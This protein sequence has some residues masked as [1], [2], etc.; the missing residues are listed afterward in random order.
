MTV[1]T[2][3]PWEVYGARFKLKRCTRTAVFAKTVLA[4]GITHLPDRVLFEMLRA[5]PEEGYAE[6]HL[7]AEG[8][9][10]KVRCY[11]EGDGCECTASLAVETVIP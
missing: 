11:K 9:E 7:K 5:D 2:G 4:L 3:V 10:L 6:W 8:V 1:R